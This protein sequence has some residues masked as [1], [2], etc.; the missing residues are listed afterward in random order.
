MQHPF[1]VL[2]PEYAQALASMKIDPARENELMVRA[3][4]ILGRANF[5]DYPSVI[6]A[7]RVPKAWGIASFERESSSDYSCSPA[8]GDKWNRVSVNVPRGLGP[9][10]DWAHAAIAAYKIDR[11]DQVALWTWARACYEGELFNGFGPRN[12]GKHS[13]Y[14]WAWTNIYDGGKY[15]LDGVW[16]PNAHD[17]QCGMIPM[18]VALLRLDPTLALADTLPTTTASKLVPI[19]APV[20]VGVGGGDHGTVWLQGALNV[21]D[22]A[23]LT[24]DGS[25]G[26]RTK[27]AVITFQ[28]AHGLTPDGLTGPLTEAALEKE[29]A[30]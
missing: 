14:L 24:V 18:M 2:V 28:T 26:R 20:P 22:K 16:D 15:V 25:Y 9:Y 23:G 5:Q 8:Q 3:D 30:A 11:L 1:E 13:G 17:Q 10:P 21:L 29:L 6:T 12:H 19:P 7:T 4:R 27:M